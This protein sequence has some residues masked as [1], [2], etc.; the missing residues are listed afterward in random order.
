MQR[1]RGSKR[2]L[3]TDE[4]CF[5]FY[6]ISVCFKNVHSSIIWTCNRGHVHTSPPLW[7]NS[8]SIF[9]MSLNSFV[10]GRILLMFSF[11]LLV[12]VLH[13]ILF[14]YLVFLMV[15]FFQGDKNIIKF[16]GNH[17]S[18]RPQFYYDSVTIFFHN[19]LSPPSY[20][21]EEETCKFLAFDL[22]D[23][24][25][26]QGLVEVPHWSPLLSS[27]CHWCSFLITSL[28]HGSFF[29]ALVSY[30]HCFFGSGMYMLPFF[31]T[32]IKILCLLSAAPSMWGIGQSSPSNTGC[33]NSR[34]QVFHSIFSALV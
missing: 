8:P 18:Q 23:F 29:E 1:R 10:T 13:L 21:F 17:N 19:I 22:D 6:F 2:C 16:E 3:L 9:C 7:S 27:S 5:L 14:L 11:S 30:N 24:P 20:L 33:R 28:L 25:S 31:I 26:L 34:R 4:L 12:M 32:R 15:F